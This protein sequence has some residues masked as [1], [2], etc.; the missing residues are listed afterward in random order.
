MDNNS[1]YIW[2]YV[3]PMIDY[4][5][6][7]DMVLSSGDV[8]EPDDDLTTYFGEEGL[9]PQFAIYTHEWPPGWN[10]TSTRVKLKADAN[11]DTVFYS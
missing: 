2:G 11:F 8:N 10:T 4:Y 9:Y 6:A 1:L 5:K 7:R 3:M